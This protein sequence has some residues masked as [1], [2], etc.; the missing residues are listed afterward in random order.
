LAAEEN[1]WDK[2]FTLYLTCELAK[3][4]EIG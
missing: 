1:S 4:K 2:Y 3:Y